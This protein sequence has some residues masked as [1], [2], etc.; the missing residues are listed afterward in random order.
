MIKK[1]HNRIKRLEKARKEFEG[2]E[3]LIRRVDD[4]I[5]ELKIYFQPTKIY[6]NLE[7]EKKKRDIDYIIFENDQVIVFANWYWLAIYSEIK[8]YYQ[9]SEKLLDKVIYLIYDVFINDDANYPLQDIINFIDDRYIYYLEENTPT[10]KILKEFYEY[11]E[12][13]W[14]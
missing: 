1:I 4:K 9:I 12:N 6:G 7:K 5:A 2:D 13:E 14:L 11:K 10:E 8:Y 3:E